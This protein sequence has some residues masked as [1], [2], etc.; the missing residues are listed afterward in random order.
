MIILVCLVTL[1]ALYCEVLASYAY[2]EHK[3]PK[4][5]FSGN[6]I[7]YAINCNR[8]IYDKFFFEQIP[9]YFSNNF[10]GRGPYKFSKYSEFK[11][12]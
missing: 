12:V 9:L 7:N 3:N 8:V 6:L 10:N 11:K 2:C 4:T 1:L 5:I